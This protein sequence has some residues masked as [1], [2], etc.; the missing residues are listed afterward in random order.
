MHTCQALVVACIDFRFQKALAGWLDRN[1]GYGNYDR[2]GLAGGVK[3]WDAIAGQIDLSKRLHHI[4]R[5]ILINHE[6]CGAYGEAGTFEKHSAD[7][8]KAKAEVLK[9]HPDVQVDLYYARLDGTV[10]AIS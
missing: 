8:R 4:G 3:D 6:D 5:V 7:L 10:E 1:V 2:V 9:K